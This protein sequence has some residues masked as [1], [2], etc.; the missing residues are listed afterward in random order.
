[1]TTAVILAA[2]QAVCSTSLPAQPKITIDQSIPQIS[3]A[4]LLAVG[5]D[6]YT[7]ITALFQ[8][9]PPLDL[10][11]S[12]FRSDIPI[13]SLDDWA[14]PT[15][16][17]IGTTVTNGSPD[18]FTF[19]FAHEMGHVMLDPRRNNGFVDAICAALALKMLDDLAIK[20]QTH[21]PLDSLRGFDLSRY[22]RLVD[23]DFSA[24]FPADIREAVRNGNWMVV[25]GYLREHRTGV[26]PTGG[27]PAYRNLQW[28]AAVSILAAPVRW[29]NLRGIA[30]CTEPRPE[31]EPAFALLP[32]SAACLQTVKD[33]DC[34]I[35]SACG[36]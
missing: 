27:S 5:E 3:H 35:G 14:K 24:M 11:I 33:I 7:E 22:R 9:R 15:E 13:T 12:V 17:R 19:Q 1:M 10:P 20:W 34:R 31:V 4:V 30:A 18:Q 26:E 29:E 2:A 21:P 16:I 23:V 32:L 6:I 25:I 36:P 28:L 8:G